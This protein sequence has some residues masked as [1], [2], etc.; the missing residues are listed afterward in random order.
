MV[1]AVE[2][3]VSLAVTSALR[4]KGTGEGVDVGYFERTACGWWFGGRKGAGEGDRD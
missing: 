4:L 1:V 2:S 3:V